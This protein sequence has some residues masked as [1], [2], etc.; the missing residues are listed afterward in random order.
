MDKLNKH[1]VKLFDSLDE[2]E[3]ALIESMKPRLFDTLKSLFK[4]MLRDIHFAFQRTF[5]G[6][7]DSETW[8]LNT[9]MARLMVPR[10]RRF[11]A[12]KKGHPEALT[13]EEW[14]DVLEKILAY[15]NMR[16][17]GYIPVRHIIDD[18]FEAVD[19]FKNEKLYE[20][21]KEHLWW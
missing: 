10:L 9:T 13:S 4:A 18:T 3:W 15:F 11:I 2:A 21:W 14:T 5:R 16:A 6:F 7:D 1:E 8:C 19:Y 17:T 12:I 20:R